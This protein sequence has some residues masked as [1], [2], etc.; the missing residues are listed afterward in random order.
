[1]VYSSNKKQGDDMLLINSFITYYFLHKS[2][3]A[4]LHQFVNE[5]TSLNQFASVLFPHGSLKYLHKDSGIFAIWKLRCGQSWNTRI[6]RLL[7]L[8]INPIKFRLLKV[9]TAKL[10]HTSANTHF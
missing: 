7:P 2:Q 5:T 6:A 4:N 10:I 8:C 1:M 9:I 3:K